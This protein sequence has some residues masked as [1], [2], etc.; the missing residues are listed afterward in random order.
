MMNRWFFFEA[1]ACDAADV[2]SRELGNGEQ[3]FV[4]NDCSLLRGFIVCDLANLPARAMEEER[5]V[6]AYQN[7]FIRGASRDR[8]RTRKKARVRAGI[9]Q[10]KS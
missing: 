4:V 6:C 3:I 2:A 9:S 1:D 10:K 5:I 8:R 7:Y